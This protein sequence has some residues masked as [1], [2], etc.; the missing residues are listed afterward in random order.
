M[1]KRVLAFAV[2][3]LFC[4]SCLFIT[5]ADFGDFSSDSDYGGYDDWGSSYDYDYDD[6]D[7]GHSSGDSGNAIPALIFIIII[8]AI[9]YINSARKN[10]G[11]FSSQNNAGAQPT[12]VSSLRPMAEYTTL[13]PKF[14]SS[15]LESQL[16]NMYVKF[17]EAWQAKNMET[18]RPYLTDTLYAKCD[19]QLEVYRQKGW[20][21]RM[22]RIAVLG[23]QLVGFKQEGSNDVIIA[24]LQ[25]RQIDYITDDATGELVR[26]NNK[27]EK[28]MTYEW[29]LLRSTGMT[30]ADSS[31]TSVQQCP[32]CGAPVNINKTAKCDYCGS[33]LTTDAMSWAVNEIK[34]LSQKT[35]S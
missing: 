11:G 27:Q 26:G 8:V 25:T 14:S 7:Y 19:R 32:H 17:Q 10:K 6:Y 2:A 23:V 29:I 16:A 3:L 34:G 30:T 21:N 31:G 35:V 28:F 4:F 13:D 33:I 12:D 20:T 24:H 1:K 18:L 9:Y 15:D 5:Q 22:E